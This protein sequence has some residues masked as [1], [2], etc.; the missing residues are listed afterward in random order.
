[1]LVLQKTSCELDCDLKHEVV[2]PGNI[3]VPIVSKAI[4]CDKGEHMHWRFNDSSNFWIC[5]PP[6]KMMK[7]P[8]EKWITWLHPERPSSLDF[9]QKYYDCY[10]R[11]SGWVPYR[12]PFSMVR[13]SEICWSAALSSARRRNDGTVIMKRVVKIREHVYAWN[14]DVASRL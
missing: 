3:T 14:I 4:K 12:S 6:H 10:R 11:W 9:P 1:M 8:E 13:G 2:L 7:L 5:K